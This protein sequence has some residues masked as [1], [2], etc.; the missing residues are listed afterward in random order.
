MLGYDKD[1]IQENVVFMEI[2]KNTEKRAIS[3]KV[4]SFS[5]FFVDKMSIKICST[6]YYYLVE[7]SVNANFDLAIVYVFMA[8]ITIM[9]NLLLI[10]ALVGSK[11]ALKNVSNIFITFMSCIDFFIGLVCFP[12]LAMERFLHIEETYV[13]NA[14]A[15]ILVSFFCYQSCFLLILIAVDRY[16]HM[17]TTFA[18]NRSI[19]LKLF[20][21]IFL[22][23][24]PIFSTTV[25]NATVSALFMR[26][27]E[28]GNTGIII[29][30][31][32]LIFSRAPAQWHV[33]SNARALSQ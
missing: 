12:V 21:G 29:T 5:Y 6:F 30:Y 8:V 15:Q 14:S 17:K 1:I 24:V 31:F 18:N 25:L 23:I 32:F 3:S 11:Q 20:S 26:L 33:T 4:A 16:L 28:F 2:I 13:Y 9:V 7:C 10:I 22:T 27:G 19:I